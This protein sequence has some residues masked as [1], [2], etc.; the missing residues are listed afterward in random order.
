MTQE[1]THP[2]EDPETWAEAGFP[3]YAPLFTKARL[4]GAIEATIRDRGLSHVAAAATLEISQDELA[5]L[6]LHGFAE[7]PID[8]LRSFLDPLRASLSRPAP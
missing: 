5:D 7:R 3:N 1:P 4:V 8:E 6:F 2:L